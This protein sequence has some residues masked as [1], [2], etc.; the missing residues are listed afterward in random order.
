[1]L[2]LLALT[3]ILI[4]AVIWLAMR[5]GRQRTEVKIT[6]DTLAAVRKAEEIENEV[7]ALPSNTLRDRAKLWVRAPRK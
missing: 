4:V 1:M 6:Q 3:A 7:Q 2:E 5:S